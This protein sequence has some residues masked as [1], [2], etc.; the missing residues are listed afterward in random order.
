M[1]YFGREFGPIVLGTFCV[2]NVSVFALF[3]VC[4][5]LQLCDTM[6]RVVVNG[7][8]TA[9]RAKWVVPEQGFSG[10]VII[11]LLWAEVKMLDYKSECHEIKSQH[12]HASTFGPLSKAP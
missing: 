12:F 11:Q 2:E 10:T 3:C 4:G 7:G 9:M 6:T 8:D 5:A 1:G